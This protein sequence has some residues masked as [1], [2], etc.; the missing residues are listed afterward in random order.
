MAIVLRFVDGKGLIQER[1]FAIVH[2]KDT[3]SMT[4]CSAIRDTLSSHNFS[5]QNLHGQRYDGASNM[6]GE[7]K[8]LQALFLKEFPHAYHVHCMAHRLQLALVVASREVKSVH[9]FFINLLI[10][11]VNVVGVS[12]KRNDQLKYAQRKDIASKIALDELDTGKGVNRKI[13]GITDILCQAF[14]QKNVDIVNAMGMVEQAKSMLNEFRQIGWDTFFATVSDFCKEHD[15]DVP[16]F[17]DPYSGER[18][19]RKCYAVTNEHYYHF[20]VFNANID[21]Q[22]AELGTR[23]DENVVDLLKLSSALDPTDGY[24]AF[25]VDAICNLARKHYYI[26][27]SE[28]EVEALEFQL[29]HFHLDVC[30]HPLLKNS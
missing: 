18:C 24:K 22:G 3:M 4:L 27:F 14:Q 23:F 20:D 2:V 7:W 1:F 12:C 5:L 15:I 28:Q 10:M 6:C 30:T 17:G 11:V 16:I 13:M 29:R 25:D 8:G 21:F 9:E 19:S 26:D